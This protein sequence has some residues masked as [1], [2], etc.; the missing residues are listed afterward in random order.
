MSD[1]GPAPSSVPPG[2]TKRVPRYRAAITL[3]LV[4]ALV[5]G[6]LAAVA[7]P[8]PAGSSLVVSTYV[9][10]DG[11]VQF[12]RQ[13]TTSAGRSTQAL[14]V[15]ESARISG[16]AVLSALD[17]NLAT[18]LIG[19]LGSDRDR[20]DRSRFW[21]TITI[22]ADYAPTSHAPTTAQAAQTRVYTLDDDVALAAESGPGL[23]FT[24]LPNLVELPADVRAG[25][26]WR[27]SGTAGAPT[28]KY[29]AEFT[30]R[31]RR[32]RAWRSA[33]R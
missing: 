16:S 10:T 22:P 28:I 24:Y 1:S 12:A 17:W 19:A 5:T 20:I 27:S 11:A 13:Q 33:A 25:Q 26:T 4:A 9:P 3:A 6:S 29:T 8:V 2:R 21:R 30:A 15:T 31:A 23:G 18:R 32:R 14:V 7:G